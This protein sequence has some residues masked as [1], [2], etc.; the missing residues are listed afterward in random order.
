MVDKDKDAKDSLSIKSG[1]SASAE[2]I[3]P[4]VAYEIDAEKATHTGA[5]GQQ[6]HPQ[7]AIPRSVTIQDDETAQRE[8]RLRRQNSVGAGPR[9]VDTTSRLV[10]EFR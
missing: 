6:A 1:R 3:L 10:G 9:Q 5:S 2:T 4:E 7:F 8:L